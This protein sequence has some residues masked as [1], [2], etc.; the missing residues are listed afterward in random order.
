MA[1]INEVEDGSEDDEDDSRQPLSTSKVSRGSHVVGP[2]SLVAEQTEVHWLK[3][4]MSSSR[5]SAGEVEFSL[6]SKG[7][8]R[9]LVRVTIHLRD[10]LTMLRTVEDRPLIEGAILKR[11]TEI[12][13]RDRKRL[14]NLQK[15]YDKLREE[16]ADTRRELEIQ[17][18]LAADPA[19]SAVVTALR[20]D[21]RVDV[22]A[23][24]ARGTFG[25]YPAGRRGFGAEII[26]LGPRLDDSRFPWGVK[27]ETFKSSFSGI[28]SHPDSFLGK[29]QP[30]L[31]PASIVQT[32]K[33]YLDEL[34]SEGP[35][36]SDQPPAS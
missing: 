36:N 17:S 27:S 1:E 33:A 9:T 16:L 34:R 22:V 5:S 26:K 4:S 25:I 24:G 32:V 7:G 21:P 6:A 29:I 14:A 2:P 20:A 28:A 8:G 10:F 3:G 15:D 13:E 18:V 30:G 12:Q 11:A 31:D 23:H 19:L 35:P